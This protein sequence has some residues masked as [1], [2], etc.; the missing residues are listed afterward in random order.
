MMTA[1]AIAPARKFTAGNPGLCGRPIQPGSATLETWIMMKMT[2]MPAMIGARR[3]R[4]NK[5]IALK[6]RTGKLNTHQIRAATKKE[7]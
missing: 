1:T 5:P 2:I 3:K 4:A 7:P 6:P